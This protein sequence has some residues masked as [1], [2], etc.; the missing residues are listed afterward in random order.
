MSGC[1]EC[2][3]GWKH[4]TDATIERLYPEP[5][6]EVGES[7]VDWARREAQWRSNVGS[8]QNTVYPCRTCN[9]PRFFRWAEGHWAQDH[10]RSACPACA[11]LDP[12]KAPRRRKTKTSEAEAVPVAAYEK[13]FTQPKETEF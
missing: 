10:D 8:G 13:D 6:R 12:G 2:E 9:A 7:D 1:G 11:D 5:Q 4:I 3:G